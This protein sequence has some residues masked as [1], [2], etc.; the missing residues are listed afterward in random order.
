M[1]KKI[2]GKSV[3]V[4]KWKYSCVGRDS[5]EIASLMDIRGNS[6]IQLIYLN[7]TLPHMPVCIPIVS[8]TREV[9]GSN[10]LISKY[11]LEGKRKETQIGCHECQQELTH[12]MIEFKRRCGQNHSNIGKRKSSDMAFLR[13][14]GL[15]IFHAS[16]SGPLS[17]FSCILYALED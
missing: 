14:S 17:T 12:I 2:L 13:V 7:S 1:W 3:K 9:E 6:K 4:Q 10:T 11:H 8:S 15:A 5:I 16:F